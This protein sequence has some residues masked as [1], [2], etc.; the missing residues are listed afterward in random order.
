M[1]SFVLGVIFGAL[2]WTAKIVG[3]KGYQRLP[4]RWPPH[5]RGWY[6]LYCGHILCSSLGQMIDR[7]DVM[8]HHLDEM[9]DLVDAMID[10]VAR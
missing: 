5:A 3:S 8:D 6:L 2:G 1:G 10:P 4:I 7:M 9:I